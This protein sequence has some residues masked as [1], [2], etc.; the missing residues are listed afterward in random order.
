MRDKKRALERIR[1]Q[2][3]LIDDVGKHPRFSPTFKKWKRDTEVMLEHVFGGETRH[4]KDFN[5]VSYAPMAFFSGTPDRVFDDRF[6]E[7]LDHSKQVLESMID[8]VREFWE[9]AESMKTTPS[10]DSTNK[11]SDVFIIHGRD[12]DFAEAVARFIE[13]R[14]LVATILHEQANKGRT[15]IEKFEQHALPCAYAIALFT[16]DDEG[17]LRNTEDAL[18]PR[19]R[20][21]VVLELGYFHGAL[22]RDRVAILYAEDVELPSD[23]A[24]VVRIPMH[25]WKAKLAQELDALQLGVAARP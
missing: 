24:G 2:M 18:K 10:P 23:Y 1:R 16:P 7:G 11:S 17:R 3:A 25:Q 5:E 12:V 22:G 21:N 14:G 13:K 9:E 20:Q 4:V 19:A 15:I 6:R 8:E